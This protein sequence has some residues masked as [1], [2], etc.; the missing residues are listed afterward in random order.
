MV[1]AIYIYKVTMC[2]NW[3]PITFSKE[4]YIF[5]Q[6]MFISKNI[7]ARTAADGRKAGNKSRFHEWLNDGGKVV[8]QE[9]S[10]TQT[11]RHSVSRTKES[12]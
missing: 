8:F 4:H 6:D 3:K 9:R 2:I 11:D 12:N 5:F 7:Y 10:F 1:G